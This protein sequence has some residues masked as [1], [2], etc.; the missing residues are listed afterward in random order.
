MNADQPM[1]L[2]MP[3]DHFAA[4]VGALAGHPMSPEGQQV[5]NNAVD[6]IV[7]CLAHEMGTPLPSRKNVM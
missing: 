6:K 3:A 2:T 5:L 1:T 7:E 4:I